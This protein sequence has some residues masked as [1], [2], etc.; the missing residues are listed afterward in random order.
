[1]P[2]KGTEIKRT[3][4]FIATDVDSDGVIIDF[5]IF[6][7]GARVIAMWE[8]WA[9]VSALETLLVDGPQDDRLTIIINYQLSG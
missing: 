4:L 6:E 3:G 8:K 5:P 7:Y 9:H 1:M 2:E